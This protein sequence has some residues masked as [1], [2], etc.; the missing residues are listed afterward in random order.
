MIV[1]GVL[2]LICVFVKAYKSFVFNRDTIELIELGKRSIR[3]GSNL[4]VSGQH[5]LMVTRD[6][7][8]LL[9]PSPHT[10]LRL[11]NNHKDNEEENEPM[12]QPIYLHNLE[13]PIEQNS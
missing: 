11:A 3:R 12:I 7:Y 2:V 10:G 6:S 1:F 4:I 9:T 5:R 13:E 8:S